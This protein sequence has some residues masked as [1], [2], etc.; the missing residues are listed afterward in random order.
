MFTE[1]FLFVFVFG[2]CQ[3]LCEMIAGE[4]SSTPK[5][6]GSKRSTCNS[7]F[8][9]TQRLGMVILDHNPSTVDADTELLVQG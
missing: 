6:E 9:M 2:M 4:C 1:V 5:E 8:K 3:E 7:Y